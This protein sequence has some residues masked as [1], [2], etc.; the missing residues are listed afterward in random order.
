MA[1]NGKWRMIAAIVGFIVIGGGLV[2]DYTLQGADI[3]DNYD[4]IVELKKDGCDPSDEN[5]KAII[6]MQKEIEYTAKT[7]DEIRVEQRLMRND[8][9]Y[10]RAA[11]EK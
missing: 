2:A 5:E 11:L 6:G 9:T 10:I 8:V 1:K 4:D 3:E 7:V